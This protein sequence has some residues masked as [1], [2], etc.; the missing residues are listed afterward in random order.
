VRR[1]VIG[2]TGYLARARWDIW[3]VPATLI[4]SCYVDSVAGSGGYPVVLPAL[5]LDSDVVDRLDGLL[6]AGGADLDPA[7]YGQPPH[8]ETEPC[9][10]R[11]ASEARLLRAAL[12]ADLPVL[13]I[14]RGMQLLAVEYGGRLHQ[15]LPEV[16][17]HRGHCPGP[18]IFGSH[19]VRTAPGSLAARHLGAAV[20]VNSHHHQGVA[21]PGGTTVTGWAD[22]GL[23]EVVEDPS[24]R[25]VL[26][27]Q[28]HPEVTPDKRVFA[29]LV[30][31]AH[32][33]PG[34]GSALL[35]PDD[36]VRAE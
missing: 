7:R 31:A 11:D 13:G 19:A 10:A 20:A 15:H 22:D 16:L 3:D 12:A 25:F 23:P 5:D 17:R 4:H 21:D 26:G 36:R 6:L 18:G 30:R 8:P 1:P 34:A 14:C 29:A 28:W 35:E 9:P 33:G 2:I 27:V 32:H 24:R